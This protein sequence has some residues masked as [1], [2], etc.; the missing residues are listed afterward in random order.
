MQRYIC[1]HAHFYQPPRENPWLEAI[2]Q[3]ESAYPYHDWNERITAEC[4]APNA[5]SR[6]LDPQHR[7]IA[8]VNNYAKI[9]FNL[10]PTL[11]AWL[12]REEPAVYHAVLEADQQSQKQFSGHGSALAQAYNHPILPLANRR[13]RI[14]QIVW[15][16]KDFERRFGRSPEGMWLPETAVDLETLDLLA[17]YGIRFTILAPHQAARA[18]R[19]GDSKWQ[20]TTAG[21]IDST[22]AYE[23]RLPSGRKI[24]LFFYNGAISRA[25]AFEGLLSRGENFAAA[26]TGAFVRGKDEA[27]LAHIATDGE[28]YGHH[29]RF[30][31]MALAYA[32]NLIEKQAVARLTNYG[33][34]LE[35]YPPLDEVEILENTSWSC[36]HGIERWRSNCGCNSGGQPDWNQEW[37]GPLRAAF[38]WLRDVLAPLYEERGRQFLREPW[39]A[40][41]EYVS[42][43]NDR[44]RENLDRF[45]ALNAPRTLSETERT[46]A[47]KMLEMQRHAM[48]MYSSCGWFFDELSGIE[49]VQALQYGARAVQLAEELFG[50]GLEAQFIDRLTLAKSNL[51]EFGDGGRIYKKS[52]EPAKLDWP[53]LAAH[54]AIGSIFEQ[55]GPAW[56]YCYLVERRRYEIHESGKTKLVLGEVR[57]TSQVT[58][59]S[60]A[61]AFAVLYLGG[62]VVTG[63]V[64]E[65]LDEESYRAVSEEII[66]PFASADFPEVIRIL[67]Q[68][69]GEPRYSLKSLFRDQQRKVV[70]QILASTLKET[71]IL[72]NRIYE[73][74]SGIMRL[75]ADLQMTLPKALAVAAEI[76]L[77][78]HLRQALSDRKVDRSRVL[79]LLHRSRSERVALDIAALEFVYRKN[80]EQHSERVASDPEQLSHLHDLDSAMELLPDLPFAVNLWKVQNIYYGLLRTVYQRKKQEHSQNGKA[81]L[82][83]F[84][85]VG[86]KIS[87]R[88][89]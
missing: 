55:D 7:I 5:V 62:H 79:G 16:I 6:V 37:R 57:M 33:E 60:R 61:M 19:L 48:L 88:V 81:W 32:L 9:S 11:L 38:D 30:G 26:L 46:V 59:D 36:S 56:T 24:A 69:L 47:L 68:R 83:C 14:T 34:F 31:E 76:T 17:Q 51:V 50:P 18:R 15:G 72:F 4:Y 41:D 73:D 2:E 64:H 3:Q 82:E 23:Q 20:E 8:L 52:V 67:D 78:H 12:E 84:T 53:R 74:H 13:D 75:L 39:A 28:S 27:Q 44:G 63:A 49:T 35:K 85:A 1:I 40:R 71:E 42:I 29:H 21:V 70:E 54:Y 86:R 80:L 58:L 66:K 45:F 77:N 65:M 22:R 43:V 10:G 25:V 87:V 89:D